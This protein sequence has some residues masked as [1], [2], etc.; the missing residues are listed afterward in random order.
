MSSLEKLLNRPPP[1]GI[2]R[3]WLGAEGAR[4]LLD[5]ALANRERFEPSKTGY[6]EHSAVDPRQR[7]SLILKDLHGIKEHLKER[8]KQSLPQMTSQL[9]VAAFTPAAFEFEMAAHGNG[10]F[11]TTHTDT[12]VK[13]KSSDTQRAISGVY[14]FHAFPKGFSGGTLRLYSP[15]QGS[16]ENR[17]HVD[18]LPDHDTLAFFPSWYPHGVLPVACPSGRFEDSRF[19][20]N[21]WV[22]RA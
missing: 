17:P 15:V 13:V 3:D 16:P 19:A 7:I 20:I 10:A 6:G 2:L 21:C 22:H 14:Y 11:F 18:I 9:G 4:K 5:F 12:F 1:H 8:L